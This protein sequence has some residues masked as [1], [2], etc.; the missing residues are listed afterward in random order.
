MS[1]RMRPSNLIPSEG[2][3]G[4]GDHRRG[5][6]C[7]RRPAARN[8][9]RRFLAQLISTTA[10]AEGVGAI[11]LRVNSG[12]GSVFASEVIR[13]EILRTRADGIPV[14]ISMGAVA[15]SGATTSPR[16]P[17]RSGRHPAPSPAVLVCSRQFPLSSSYC[18]ESGSIPTVWARRSWQVPAPRPAAESPGGRGDSQWRRFQL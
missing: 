13:Q 2:R 5:Q 11:V 10:E 12:G 16:K 17:T 7:P 3:Q 18:S 15:A 14:V 6:Y 4:G 9:R 8:H 1:R